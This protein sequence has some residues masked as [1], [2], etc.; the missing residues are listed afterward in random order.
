MQQV[1]TNFILVILSRSAL[2]HQEHLR[3]LYLG[4]PQEWTEHFDTKEGLPYYYNQHTGETT[5]SVP[6]ELQRHQS[7]LE[8]HQS[9]HATV[10]KTRSDFE[11]HLERE[12]YETWLRSERD[13]NREETEME[14]KEAQKKRDHEREIEIQMR[15][16][17]KLQ[18]ERQQEEQR[19]EQRHVICAHIMPHIHTCALTRSHTCVEGWRGR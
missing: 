16:E 11:N 3:L 2:V 5:W 7:V 10:M 15:L 4:S 17:K 1:Q 19:E 8:A 18:E 13:V 14:C 6:A 9:S 12:R